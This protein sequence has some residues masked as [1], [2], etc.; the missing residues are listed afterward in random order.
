MKQNNIK[1]K[2]Y[3]QKWQQQWLVSVGGGQTIL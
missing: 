3:E 2:E 1:F